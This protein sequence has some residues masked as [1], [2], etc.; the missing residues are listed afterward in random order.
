LLRQKATNKFSRSMDMYFTRVALE[1]SSGEQIAQHRTE[2]FQR[3][4]CVGEEANN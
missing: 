2:R 4:R 1:Q 3:F